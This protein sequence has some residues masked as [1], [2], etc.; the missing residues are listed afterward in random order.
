MQQ[1]SFCVGIYVHVLTLRPNIEKNVLEKQAVQKAHHDAHSHERSWEI[2][3]QVMVKNM[4]PGPLWV[5]G[6]IISQTGPV[7]YQIQT[8]DAQVWK[9]HVDHLKPLEETNQ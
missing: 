3:Q 7:S 8:D 5:P 4:R 1:P 9:R 6:R 2:G